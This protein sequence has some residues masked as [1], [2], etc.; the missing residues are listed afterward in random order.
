MSAG[1]EFSHSDPAEHVYD[2]AA[3]LCDKQSTV[4]ALLHGDYMVHTGE[5]STVREGPR[6][7][8]R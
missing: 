2:V 5:A 8:C 7:C 3:K 4:I 1:I 6:Y